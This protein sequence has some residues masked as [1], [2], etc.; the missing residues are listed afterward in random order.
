MKSK[1]TGEIL[2][3]NRPNFYTSLFAPNDIINAPPQQPEFQK[4]NR[5]KKLL[6]TRDRSPYQEDF[7]RLLLKF[8]LWRGIYYVIWLKKPGFIIWKFRE[9]MNVTFLLGMCT[10]PL[11][12][13]RS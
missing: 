4:I 11:E 8:K 13:R 5:E 10:L 6:P 9:E 2:V 12:L 1:I 7:S 3:Q